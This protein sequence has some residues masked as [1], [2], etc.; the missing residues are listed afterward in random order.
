MSIIINTTIDEIK[1]KYKFEYNPNGANDYEEAQDIYYSIIGRLGVSFDDY[2]FYSRL[3][4]L[5]ELLKKKET[6]MKSKE[7]E[8]YENKIN[9]LK[10]RVK[11]MDKLY[12]DEN[13]KY[14]TL[15]NEFKQSYDINKDLPD[16]LN[17]CRNIFK[18]LLN[19]IYEFSINNEKKFLLINDQIIEI[20]NNL[21]FLF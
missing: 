17:I 2:H 4:K 21:N 15:F 13:L 1:K 11:N 14:S 7:F 18:E 10:V 6:K 12:H 19:Q 8:F 20:N 9:E 5:N 3:K 16:A